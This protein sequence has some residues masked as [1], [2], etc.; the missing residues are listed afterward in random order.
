[1]DKLFSS[2][3]EMQNHL[4]AKLLA[5][6]IAK[7]V[8]GERIAADSRTV[9][10]AA[11]ALSLTALASPPAAQAASTAASAYAYSAAPPKIHHARHTIFVPDAATAQVPEVGDSSCHLEIYNSYAVNPAGHVH[12]LMTMCGTQ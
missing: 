3:I 10:L 1:M 12:R 7:G 4:S 11:A 6:F 2:E 9:I 5:E 8:K